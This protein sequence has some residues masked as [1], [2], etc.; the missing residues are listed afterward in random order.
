MNVLQQNL[1][2]YLSFRR[3]LGFKLKY[4]ASA[5][6][7]FVDFMEAR[8]AKYITQQLALDWA[9]ETRMEKSTQRARRLQI[10]R[11]FARYV[12]AIDPRTEIPA[13]GLLYGKYER[14]TPYIYTKEQILNLIAAAAKL[15]PQDGL[16]PF[17]YSTVFGLLAV[18]GM[19]VGEIVALD[20]SDV[21]FNEAVLTVR[22]GKFGKSRFIP[23]HATTIQ[24]LR[25]YARH[26]DKVHPAPSS[27]AFFLSESG[28]RLTT[29]M[30]RWTF[31]RLSRRIGLRTTTDSNGPRLHDLRHTFAVRTFVNW[32][33]AGIAVDSQ[34]LALST[35]LGHAKVTDTYWYLSSIP[36]LLCLANARLTHF[37]EEQ[38]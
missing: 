12:S 25:V 4:P 26:R 10:V 38:P 18:T 20:R 15:P 36:E 31:I 24:R 17:S 34:I 33:R 3:N 9:L 2:E 8:R 21:D 37:L 11:S 30:V 28:A 1:K 22:D 19:R 23:V 5:L 32:Y 29:C 6:R 27:V 16:R 14:A 35:Y 13:D 7:N